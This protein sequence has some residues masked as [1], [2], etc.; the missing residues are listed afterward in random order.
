MAQLC[1]DAFHHIPAPGPVLVL[2]MS[3]RQFAFCK[4]SENWIPGF[5]VYRM[6]RWVN[7]HESSPSSSEQVCRWH[8]APR[9]GWRQP[10]THWVPGTAASPHWGSPSRGEGEIWSTFQGCSFCIFQQ[11]IRTLKTINTGETLLTAA[12]GQKVCVPWEKGIVHLVGKNRKHML[13]AV[14]I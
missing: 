11:Q 4:T 1:K 14:I 2:H 3:E 10:E 13:G 8:Q 9:G 6:Y 5:C 7:K 12:Y